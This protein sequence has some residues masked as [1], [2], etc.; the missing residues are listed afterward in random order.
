[1]SLP[2][3]D[4]PEIQYAGSPTSLGAPKKLLYPKKKLV[5]IGQ[6]GMA[7][8][9]EAQMERALGIGIANAISKEQNKALELRRRARERAIAHALEK[10]SN[11]PM[12][13]AKRFVRK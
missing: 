11:N 4:L 3:P 13:N 10:A 2:L 5:H 6:A 8:N 7:S 1:M 9:A 12:K